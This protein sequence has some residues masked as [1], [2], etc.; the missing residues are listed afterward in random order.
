MLYSHRE[1]VLPSTKGL[2]RENVIM[3]EG[4]AQGEEECCMQ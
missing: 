3:Q 1:N 2:R 4:D